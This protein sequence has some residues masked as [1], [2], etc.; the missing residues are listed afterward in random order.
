VPFLE[1]NP[2][3]DIRM[4][5]AIEEGRHVFCHVYQSLSHGEVR[6]VTADLFDTD[7]SDR[8]V[9]HWDVREKIGPPE[10]RNNSGKF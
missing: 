3:R 9:L 1:R 10:T 8:I 7:S 2:I 6:W 5:R 4:A